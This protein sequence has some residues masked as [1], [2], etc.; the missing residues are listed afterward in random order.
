MIETNIFAAEVLEHQL[1]EAQGAMVLRVSAKLISTRKAAAMLGIPIGQYDRTPQRAQAQPIDRNSSPGAVAHLQ[2]CRALRSSRWK[3]PANIAVL[4]GAAIVAV[5]Q[6][7]H[8]P[9]LNLH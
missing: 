9:T 1:P 2:G 3:A 5:W 4:L 7:W 8:L 6:H